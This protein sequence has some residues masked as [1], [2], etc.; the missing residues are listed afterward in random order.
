MGIFTRPATSSVLGLAHEAF[1]HDSAG[2]D[3]FKNIRPIKLS[4]GD[5]LRNIAEGVELLRDSVSDD[6]TVLSLE[7][8]NPFPSALGLRPT[9]YGKN[10]DFANTH[11]AA[12]RDTRDST[13]T[14]KAAER[15]F[16]DAQYVMVPEVPF[17]HVHLKIVIEKYGEYLDE[18]FVE[19]RRS[20]HW[21][22]YTRR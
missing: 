4:Q 5:Y 15:Y 14:H 3:R 20:P 9:T 10:F 21:R 13:P 16:S 22:L 11:I 1:G 12:R 7:Q 17:N 19:Y 6:A 18:H 2:H 8:T